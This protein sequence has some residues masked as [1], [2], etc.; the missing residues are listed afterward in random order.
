MIPI[1]L[2]CSKVLEKNTYIETLAK[3][4]KIKKNDIYILSG[5]KKIFRINEIRILYKI[6]SRENK[7]KRM[8][9][10]NNFET[11][12][13]ETQNAFLKLLEE[14]N[15]KTQFILVI[16]NPELILPTIL[17]RCK[18]IFLERFK[19]K[20]KT[21]KIEFNFMQKKISTLFFENSFINRDSVN[22][23]LNN[24]IRSFRGNKKYLKNPYILK[25]A[26]KVKNYIEKNY[27]NSQLA[28]DHLLI[29]IKS[30][31]KYKIND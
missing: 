11:A 10:L 12:K 7:Q 30:F 9:I 23:I 2:I 27:I 25:E 19:K 13:I 15:D 28:F 24:L 4:K 29:L 22:I 17:S 20:G 18:L 21:D 16:K 5:E 3:E 8:I 6:L 31:D 1:I 26:I 14:K